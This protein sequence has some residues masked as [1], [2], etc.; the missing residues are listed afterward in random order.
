VTSAATIV[1]D[2]R[3]IAELLAEPAATRVA[4]AL[5]DAA[6][7]RIATALDRF[8]RSENF[9]QALGLTTD[10]RMRLRIDARDRALDELVKHFPSF[11]VNALAR[12]IAASVRQAR[13]AGARPDGIA[14][15]IWDLRTLDCPSERHLRRLL[16]DRVG[17]RDAG[18]GQLVSPPCPRKRRP[19]LGPKKSL[20]P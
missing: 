14:G 17:Q 20:R 13:G 8:I 18:D 4:T 2:V 6:A 5:D 9:D 15:Y 10:W 3:R 16:T 7:M 1:A 12:H 11:S 19:T